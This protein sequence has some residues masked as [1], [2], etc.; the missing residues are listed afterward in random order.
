MF[1]SNGGQAGRALARPGD[2]GGD[3]AGVGRALLAAA[4]SHCAEDDS[5]GAGPTL[6]AAAD[7]H[8]VEG[9]SADVGRTMVGEDALEEARTR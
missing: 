8:C 5:T 7:S 3:P 9:N 4:D 6:F 1:R 2:F